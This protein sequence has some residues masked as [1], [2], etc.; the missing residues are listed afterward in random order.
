MK[1]TDHFEVW[2]FR[3]LDKTQHLLQLKQDDIAQYKY[4]FNKTL[5]D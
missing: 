2:A 5:L 1:I 3:F 4:H